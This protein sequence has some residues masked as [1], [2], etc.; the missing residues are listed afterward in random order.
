MTRLTTQN[1]QDLAA[2]RGFD[3]LGENP[4]Y[5][6]Q[7]T[8][9]KCANGHIWEARYND[10]QQGRGCPQCAGNA[11]K[12]EVD[13]A[14]AGEKVNADW[15]GQLVNSTTKTKWQCRR[16]S[17]IWETTY[18]SIAI[19]CGC[20][21]CARNLRLTAEDYK[22]IAES[23]GVSWIGI[24]PET[25][26]QKTHWQ[27]PKGHKWEAP[28]YSIKDGHACPYCRNETLS[29]ERR[30]SPVAYLTLAEQQGLIWLGKHP[31]RNSNTPT[32]WGCQKNHKWRASYSN[33]RKGRGCPKCK[34]MVNGVLVSN[35]QRIV[36]DM[37]DGELNYPH[38]RYFIDVAIRLDGVPIAIEYD[39]WYW[40]QGKEEYDQRRT[41]TLIEDGW[42]VLRIKGGTQTPSEDELTAVLIRLTQGSVYEEIVMPDWKGGE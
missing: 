25:A 37:L 10:I 20:P 8:T 13:F 1:F 40:H 7:K 23:M 29:K 17:H 38:G 4:V 39:C 15:L 28:Y 36:A 11:R 30:H 2:S 16:C 3:W 35:P 9:W 21:K 31:P 27:C 41:K 33:I 12:T 32:T 6:I 42:H 18:A 26:R 22:T 34:G 24:I 19:G 5:A 14:Q